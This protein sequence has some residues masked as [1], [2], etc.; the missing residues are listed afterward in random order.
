MAERDSLV[1]EEAEEAEAPSAAVGADEPGGLTEEE[2]EQI[3]ERNGLIR[4]MDAALADIRQRS[5]E[6][7]LTTS[8]RW[9][10]RSFA[11]EGM[12][13]DAFEEK[14]LLYIQERDHAEA[15]PVMGRIAVPAPL[16]EAAGDE[17]RPADEPLPDLDVSDIA[18]MPGKKGIYLYSVALLSHSFARALFLTSEDDEVATFV[19]VVRTESRVY[20]RPVSINS[21]ANPPYLWP[22]DKTRRV[23]EEVRQAGSFEDIHETKTTKDE[24]FY[25]ST[26]YLSDAQGASLAQWYGVERGMNP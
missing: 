10:K 13:S 3:R 8:S 12:T 21:F 7:K 19:D 5:R 14:L 20:P 15:E 11:P 17:E 16:D 26:L 22:H 4:A 6:G 23:F 9:A 2:L 1:T 25:Y 18:I 24:I